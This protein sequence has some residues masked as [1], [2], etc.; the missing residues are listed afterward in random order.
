MSKHL[1]SDL[2]N[3]LKWQGAPPIRWTS[4]LSTD[5]M[6][7]IAEALKI[8]S[9]CGTGYRERV[10]HMER[11]FELREP[12][13]SSCVINTAPEGS[14]DGEHW[15][16]LY[17][18]PYPDI[19]QED[20]HVEFFDCSGLLN[21]MPAVDCLME[22][23]SDGPDRNNIPLPIVQ[24]TSVLQNGM[25]PDSP[26]CGYH[27]MY[28]IMCK[29]KII[30]PLIKSEEPIEAFNIGTYFYPYKGLHP[31]LN[32]LHVMESIE[33]FLKDRNVKL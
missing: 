19:G 15:V 23:L 5:E 30:P 32:D 16:A 21:V 14:K 20:H 28:Y 26:A 1:I 29:D 10:H 2:V 9:W 8:P 13:P 33:W 25:N 27:C 31:H 18:T 6:N 11:L 7:V 12:Y 4:G 24:N 22:S 3:N 17:Y